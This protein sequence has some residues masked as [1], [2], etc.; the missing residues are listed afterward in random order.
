MHQKSI[1]MQGYHT[2]STGTGFNFNSMTALLR[3]YIVVNEFFWE[4]LV[5]LEDDLRISEESLFVGLEV[6]DCWSDK[7]S[8]L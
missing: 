8:F 1:K 7:K 5:Q 4:G 3:L 6:T 2:I